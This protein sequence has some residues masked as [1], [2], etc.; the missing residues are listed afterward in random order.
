MEP[1][2][3]SSEPSW[4]GSRLG[5]NWVADSPSSR[6]SCTRASRF[7]SRTLAEGLDVVAEWEA[8]GG[9]ADGE[10]VGRPV[11]RHDAPCRHDGAGADAHAR[12]DER[13]MRHPD[14]IPD[15]DRTAPPHVRVA[16]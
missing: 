6:A 9:I 5:R 8:L 11:G 7:R 2:S 1:S 13:A 16:K 4:A 3:R 14:V 12:L 10:G 15:E